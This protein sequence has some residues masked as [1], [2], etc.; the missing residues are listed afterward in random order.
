RTLRPSYRSRDCGEESP[1]AGNPSELVFAPLLE[2]DSRADNKILDRARDQHFSLMGECSDACGDV[3]G[4]ASEVVAA[5]FALPSAYTDAKVDSKG[6]RRSG[7]LAP[8]ELMASS[9]RASSAASGASNCR[10]QRSRSS[11]LIGAV[12]GRASSL[13]ISS[14]R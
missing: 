9:K 14:R 4:K 8:T 13:R 1:G 12:P 2:G 11:C 10:A 7:V 5:D 6:S 3:N